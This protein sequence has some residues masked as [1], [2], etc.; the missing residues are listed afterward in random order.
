MS[1]HR[2]VR[3]A[4]PLLASVL[5][6]AA[7]PLAWTQ[8]SS[9]A[10]VPP[11]AEGAAGDSDQDPVQDPEQTGGLS[12][13]PL[14]PAAEIPVEEAQGNIEQDARVGT[15]RNSKLLTASEDD[16]YPLSLEEA[17]QLAIKNNL[18]IKLQL[19][20]TDIAQTNYIGAWGAFD[21]VIGLSLDFED[22]KIKLGQGTD[23]FVPTRDST[24]LNG[25]ANIS[26]PFTTGGS[27]EAGIIAGGGKGTSSFDP[28]TT[29]DERSGQ[30][31][32]AYTQP[33]TRGAWEKYAT[34][35]QRE[36][37]FDLRQ[38][39]E[40][41]RQV[42]Q[43]L[44]IEVV[45]AY[46]DLVAAREARAVS[47]Q[48]LELATEQLEQNDRRLE[49]GVGTEVDVLQAETEVATR[50][51]ELLL[52]RKNVRAAEDVLK[53]TIFHREEEDPLENS[54]GWWERPLLPTT[55]LPA[56]EQDARFDWTRSLARALQYRSIL[57][58]QRYEIQAQNVNL[59]RATSNRMGALDFTASV[60]GQGLDTGGLGGAVEETLSFNFPTARIGLNYSQTLRNR[61]AIQAQRSARYQ[62][63]LA[64]L[65]YDQSERQVLFEVRAS[66]RE[67]IYQGEAVAAAQKSVDLAER[68]LAA[69]QARFQEGLSTTFQVFQFQKTLTD[70]R[71]ALT[72]ARADYA[73]ARGDL[74]KA[75]GLLGEDREE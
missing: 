33:L 32:V 74:L 52:A 15:T 69:E 3:A 51:A 44:L 13:P 29:F 22:S 24:T 58:Q 71:F 57:A 45:R 70:T 12:V 53:D 61:T 56:V 48:A 16:A 66:V 68:Q 23:V 40:Q 60:Q 36:S 63:R 38:Q 67:V 31:S 30:F 37:R 14:R 26:V 35:D 18:S 62:I 41:T 46:W 8:E 75:E 65:Q 39:Q 20:A 28:G 73:K 5:L 2:F 64:R 1:T 9:P 49:V 55:G 54:V 21:P 4:G 19:L 43:E 27:L 47:V 42:R 6:L 59:E 72:R 17:A 25:G 11:T 10:E 50:E 7:G 34:V